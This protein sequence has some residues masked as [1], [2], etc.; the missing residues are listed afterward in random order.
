MDRIEPSFTSRAYRTTTITVERLSAYAT[1]R[2]ELQA[3]LERDPIAARIRARAA[4][5]CDRES[6]VDVEYTM[7]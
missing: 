4:R 1:E 3:T 2:A 5:R 7:V 6:W